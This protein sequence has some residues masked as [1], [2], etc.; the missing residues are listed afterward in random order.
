MNNQNPNPS[1][2][3]GPN[4]QVLNLALAGI[5]I[6]LGTILSFLKLFDLPYGGSVTICGMLP[7]MVF[8]YRAGPK[9]GLGAGLVF[10]VLQ[11]LFGLDALKGVSGATVVGSIFLDYLLAFTVLWLAGFF[12]GKLKSHATDFTLGCLVAGL[13]RYLCSFLSGWILWSEYADANFSPILAGMSGQQLAFFYSLVYN[14]GYMIPEILIT[15]IA[16]F[17]VMQFAG[18]QILK[19]T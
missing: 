10:S 2:K 8:A 1:V 12:R 14:G 5:L 6:A 7:V 15:C 17:L 3:K 19:G 16:G 18:Q 9:W 13:L 11:L 4:H